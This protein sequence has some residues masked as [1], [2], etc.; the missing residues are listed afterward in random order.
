MCVFCAFIRPAV[1]F[2]LA[3]T[4]SGAYW[5]ENNA[6]TG[7]NPWLLFKPFISRPF[8][9][10]TSN[11]EYIQHVQ[12]SDYDPS[13]FKA[14]IIMDSRNKRQQQKKLWRS[15]MRIIRTY[16]ALLQFLGKGGHLSSKE[17]LHR[18]GLT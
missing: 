2:L 1:L 3:I 5:A 13:V 15:G 16:S 9:K 4:C 17:T 6:F 11:N 8:G 10:R 18:I 14:D 7:Q 12:P